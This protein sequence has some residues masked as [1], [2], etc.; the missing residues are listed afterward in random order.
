LPKRGK[1]VIKFNIARTW[2]FR[3]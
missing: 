1:A 3:E 2:N